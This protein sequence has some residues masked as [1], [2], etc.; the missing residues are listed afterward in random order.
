M[1][2]KP[3]KTL[4]TGESMQTIGLAALAFTCEAFMLIGGAFI[5][6]GFMLAILCCLVVIWI[7]YSEINSS[8]KANKFSNI[9]ALPLLTVVIVFMFGISLLYKDE[10][11]FMTDQRGSNISIIK[12]EPWF[13]DSGAAGF[14]YT[15]RNVG[16][17]AATNMHK[18]G[19]V[20][21]REQ[22]ASNELLDRYFFGLQAS[23]STEREGGQDE[24]PP[25]GRELQY[26]LPNEHDP[27][28]DHI[29]REYWRSQSREMGVIYTLSVYK[30]RDERMSNGE[31]KV[32][33][34]CH[35]WYANLAH[36]CGSHNR[37][38]LLKN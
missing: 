6:L 5:A 30:F 16:K 2:K 27:I 8:I 28:Q 26:S 22:L 13:P 17:S 38:F 10:I 34:L 36:P 33:E 12:I 23:L 3:S 14:N 18:M 15:F 31:W 24:I 19:V 20:F 29:L 9:L 11:L 25:R 4:L 7:H 35:Y 32:V 21:Y 37:E 1:V